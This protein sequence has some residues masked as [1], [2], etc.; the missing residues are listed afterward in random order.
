MATTALPSRYPGATWDPVVPYTSAAGRLHLPVMG[1]VLHVQDGNG[2]PGP[3]FGRLTSNRKFSHLWSAKVGGGHQ[4]QLLTYASWA[5]GA[6]GNPSWIS[7]ETEGYPGEPLTDAQLDWLAA[8]HVWSGLPDV[9]TNNPSVGG[10]GTHAMGG[11]AWGGHPNCPGAIR[12]AQRGEI[13]ARARKLRAGGVSTM[14]AVDLT[15]GALQA[16]ADKLEGGKPPAEG[17]AYYRAHDPDGAGLLVPTDAQTQMLAR[18]A[19]LEAQLDALTA[20]VQRA[21]Q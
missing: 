1:W 5:Q 8:W 18:L 13:L 16:I 4:Y 2:N 17:G 19:R 9:L 12:T 20:L 3:Y 21:V 11:T 6:G 10:I 7:V 15:P 14:P